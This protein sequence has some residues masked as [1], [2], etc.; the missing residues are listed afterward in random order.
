MDHIDT[1]D[2]EIAFDDLI[3]ELNKLKD[4]NDLVDAY[5]DSIDRMSKK[6]N[7]LLN[8]VEVFYKNAQEHENKVNALYSKYVD[9]T[10]QIQEFLAKEKSDTDSYRRR[11]KIVKGF[12]LTLT[13]LNLICL[14]V[15]MII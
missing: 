8:M 2:I 1:H 15:H 3:K 11:D 5:K 4:L 10:S 9:G 13:V 7:D 6:T 14:I 12:V